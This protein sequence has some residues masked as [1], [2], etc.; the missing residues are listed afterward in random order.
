MSESFFLT[1]WLIKLFGGLLVAGFHAVGVPAA[2][3]TEKASSVLSAFS[4]EED[5]L[6]F[7]ETLGAE[8]IDVETERAVRTPG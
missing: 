4:I 7:F 1:H 2:D 3:A 5:G 6:H 8:C